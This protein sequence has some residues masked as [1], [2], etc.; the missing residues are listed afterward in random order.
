MTTS[1]SCRDGAGGSGIA[2]CTDQNNHSSGARLDTATLGAHTMT[3]TASSGD[4]LTTSVSVTY[5]VA[6][7]PAL[8]GLRASPHAFLAATGGG[9]IGR[10]TDVGVQ[11]STEEMGRY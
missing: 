4:G 1:F 11:L 6:R 7:R 2:S 3:V 10:G 9:P 5:T 8:T